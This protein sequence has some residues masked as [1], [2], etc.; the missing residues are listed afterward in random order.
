[1]S[2]QVFEIRKLATAVVAT[3]AMAAAGTA[4]AKVSAE[5]AAKLG[6]TLTP[7]GAEKAGNADGSIPAWTGGLTSKV[8]RGTN[9]F[10]DEKPLYVITNANK[11]QYKA[12]LSPGQ[13]A[14]LA[15]YPDTYN[16]P[17]YPTHR[18]AVLPQRIY[19]KVKENATSAELVNLAPTN[20]VES[21][22]FPIPQNA[23]EIIW[24]HELRYRGGAFKRDIMQAAVQRNGS[25]TP[26]KMTEEIIKPWYLTDGYDAEKD[27]NIILYMK[28]AIKAPARLTGTT[29]LVLETLDQVKQPRLAWIYNSGQ[30]RVRRAPQVAYDGPGTAADGLRTADNWD[31]FN[32]ALDKYDWK[33]VG[34]QEM[35]IPY[36]SYD[37]TNAKYDDLL[38]AGHVNPDLTRFEKHR[39]WVV[40]AT[41]KEGERNIYAKR[42]FY[43]DE[44]N[45][46]IGV[47]DYYDG[48]NE[49]WRVG[50]HNAIQYTEVDMPFSAG[51]VIHDLQSG[52]YIA[53][54][55]VNEEK[56]YTFNHK[57]SHGDFTPAALRRDS[58][59]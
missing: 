54:S 28:Q 37:F 2:K 14:L 42:V 48:R 50:L 59:R 46:Q 10:A 18:T 35:L 31:L 1:M 23:A 47:A 58:K 27:G 3:L 52:R 9:P 22:P 19:D 6:N 21:V 5:E 30:R 56:G 45:W 39:V 13:M 29:L 12:L 7:G 4:L 17:V 55:L 43:V 26:V 15:K 8:K 40:E 25:Y 38:Q 24:N 20:F 44:D 32:G 36:N 41:L 34:K 53:M 16:M 11:D 51:E 57:A 33:L 49:L